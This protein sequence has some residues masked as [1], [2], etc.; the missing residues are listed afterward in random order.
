MVPHFLTTY[1]FPSGDAPWTI[2]DA[3]TRAFD[4][5]QA[6]ASLLE[7]LRDGGNRREGP[8]TGKAKTGTLKKAG[9]KK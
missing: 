1:N 2:G 3:T 7:Q 6:L 9:V 4:K 8:V 5:A